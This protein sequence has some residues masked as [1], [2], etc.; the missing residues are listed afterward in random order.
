MN[1]S[2][3]Y[4]RVWEP[5]FQTGVI[6][7]CDGGSDGLNVAFRFA[8]INDHGLQQALA[9]RPAFEIDR[10]CDMQPQGAL[11]VSFFYDGNGFALNILPR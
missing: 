9:A 8:N 6:F 3:G 4:I 2:T 5:L 11:R 7:G 10:N 1:N